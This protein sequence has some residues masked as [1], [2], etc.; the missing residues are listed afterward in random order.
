MLA[1][2]ERLRDELD[3]ED[4][5][6]P[7][8]VKQESDEEVKGLELRFLVNLLEESSK[9]KKIEF[10]PLFSTNCRKHQIYVI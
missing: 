2:E 7:E 6:Q 3:G 10:S 8:M 5:K 4:S 9:R 1:E